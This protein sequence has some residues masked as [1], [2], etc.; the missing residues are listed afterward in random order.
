MEAT[1]LYLRY[2]PKLLS[3]CKQYAKEDDVAEDLLHDAFVII[4]TSLDK[5]EDSKKLESWMTSIVRN[6]G[7]HYRQH[8]DKEQSALK[9]FIKENQETTEANLTPEYDQLQSLVAQ[10]PQGYQQVFRLS[11]FEGLSHQEISQLLGIAP[12]SSSSQLSHAKR[13]LRYLIR[14]LWILVLFFV[15]M[16]TSVWLFLQKKETIKEATQA[17]NEVKKTEG[18]HSIDTF[19]D[20]IKPQPTQ[21]FH[22]KHP[23]HITTETDVLDNIPQQIITSHTEDIQE[24]NNQAQ[25]DITHTNQ[26]PDRVTRYETEPRLTAQKKPSHSWNISLTY[27]GLV[28]R[29]DNYLAQT[30]IGK[31]S[32]AAASNLMMPIQFNNW[33]DYDFYLNTA[34]GVLQDAETRSIMAIAAQNSNINGGWME[35]HYEHKHPI[36]LQILLNRQLTKRIAVETGLSYTQLNSTITT[37][38]SLAYIQEE[39]HLRYLGIP[40]R[41]GWQWYNKSH[42]SLY[43]SAG[44]M[45]EW[46][47]KCTTNIHHK[48]D[49]INTFQKE[50]SPEVSNQWS[51]TLGVGLQYNITPSLGLYLEPSFQYFFNDGSDIKSYRTEHPLQMTLPLGIRFQW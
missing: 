34:Q 5:L 27:S 7:Y 36:T 14:Q 30:T 22:S 6:V 41:L 3:I 10:L 25:S 15:A 18:T 32:F 26:H 46:P 20:V 45:A 29:N 51:T 4:L 31:S 43:S 23:I 28:G 12:H 38:S 47:I 9:Q 8:A 11:V 24:A 19:Q 33:I 39:Q 21:L 2:K 37:G 17:V 50:T 40:I 49:N 1:D 48:V 16:P 13:M 42:I 35:A 44:V